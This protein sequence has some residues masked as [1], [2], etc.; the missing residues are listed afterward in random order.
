MQQAKLEGMSIRR[1]A[2]ELGNHRDTVRRYIDAESPPTRGPRSHP[3]RR[4]LIPSRTKR[5]TFLPNG[6][7]DI[8]PEL[9]QPQSGD[10]AAHVA[11]FISTVYKYTSTQS[12]YRRI[13]TSFP[14]RRE[15]ML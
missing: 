15:G 3:Q 9:R 7:T 2:R 10:R 14:M 5:V 12:A 11:H 13:C 6:F 1:M 8:Y 4:H